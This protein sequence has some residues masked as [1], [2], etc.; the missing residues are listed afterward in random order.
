MGDDISERKRTNSSTMGGGGGGEGTSHHMNYGFELFFGLLLWHFT[1][2]ESKRV[3]RY[4]DGNG[5]NGSSETR[6]IPMDGGGGGER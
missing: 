2:L 1:W 4:G 6:A 5:I 3:G